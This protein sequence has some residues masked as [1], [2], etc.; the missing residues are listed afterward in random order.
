MSDILL[1]MVDLHTH[2]FLSD[3]ALGPGEL[4][5]RA[6]CAGYRTM[7]ITD[8][9][10]H[11]T[12]H[13]IVAQI[14]MAVDAENR[15]GRMRVIPGVEITHVR[16]EQIG[17]VARQ[18][19]EAGALIVLCHG[20]TI[21]EPVMPGTNR[22][23]IEAGV[24]VLAHPGLIS[25]EDVKRAAA[26]NV[27]LEIT[28]K[29]GHSYTNAHVARLARTHGATLVY[30]SDGHEPSHLRRREEAIRIMQ[31]AGITVVEAEMIL[32][33]TERLLFSREATNDAG[34]GPF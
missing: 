29:H 5:R 32:T 31:G 22:A 18:A 13:A 27:A 16:P 23:A 33:E 10:D 17:E 19:R 28:A 15:V 25:E 7:A 4:I 9:V 11:G 6:E 2:T 3:G 34:N 21:C 20:E 14:R 30:G 8:H 12:V 26:R 24:D 1:P